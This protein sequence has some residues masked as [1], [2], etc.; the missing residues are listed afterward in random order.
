MNYLYHCQK[1]F[2]KLLLISSCLFYKKCMF[3]TWLEAC[4]SAVWVVG[5]SLGWTAPMVGAATYEA[6]WHEKELIKYGCWGRIGLQQIPVG[7]FLSN[8]FV[9]DLF[10]SALVTL[11]WTYILS[12]LLSQLSIRLWYNR[13]D[14]AII[15]SILCLIANDGSR[16]MFKSDH[17]WLWELFRTPNKGRHHQKLHRSHL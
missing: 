9:H 8:M 11:S 4:N 14:S 17:R 2:S 15:I 13:F 12:T 5:P 1:L 16:G 6:E 3:G 10:K 7:F